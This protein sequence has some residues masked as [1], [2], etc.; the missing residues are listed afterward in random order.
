MAK[1]LQ[2]QT[3]FTSGELTPRLWAHVD[4]AKYKNGLKEAT[5]CVVL[6]H[7]PVSRRNGFK[8]INEVKDSSKNVRLLRFE[9][10][11]SDAYIL[12]MGDLYI[13]FY[14]NG[15]Q[16]QVSGVP[17]ELTTTYTQAEIF[18]ITYVQ[19]GRLLYIFHPNHPPA[20]L[21][22]TNS[23]SWVLSDIAFYPKP[24]SEEGWMPATTITPGATTGTGITFTA[25]TTSIFTAS[26]VGRQI[27]NLGGA[28]KASITAYTDTQHVVCTILENFPSTSSITSQNWKVD[29][30]PITSLTPSGSRIGAIV[31][32]TSVATVWEG[33]H[34]VSLPNYFLINNGVIKT[35][36]ITSTTVLVGEV[37][38][39]LDAVTASANWTA[40][41]PIWSSTFSYP[42]VCALHQQRLWAASTTHD[43]QRV[44][45]SESG[46]LT[47][48][49]AGSDDSDALDFNLSNREVSKVSWLGNIRGQLAI[50]TTSSEITIDSGTAAG[51]I[52]PTNLI[53]Q[54][55]GYNGSNLQ[56][57]V[58]LDDEILYIQRSGKKINAFS[59]NFQID[60]YVSTDLLFLAEHMPGD[61][62]VKELAY[63]HDPD[64]NIYA[65]LNDGDLLVCTY[66]K[67][68]DVTAWSRYSTQGNF[69]SINTI[70]TGINDEVWVVV[71]RTINGSTKRYIEKLDISTGEG[72]TDGFSDCYLTYSNPKTITAITNAN[73]GVVTSAAHGFNNGDFIKF[74]DIEGLSD[75]TGKTFIVGS[76]TT[77]TFNILDTSSQNFDTTLLGTF[78]SGVVHKLVTTISGLSYLEGQT[79]QVKADG[80]KH[81]D[82]VVSSG[83]IILDKPHY[84]VTVGLE[85]T[86][87]ITT[88]VKEYNQGE[89][90]M[91][92]QKVRWIR[93]V[94]RLYKSALPTINDQ[95]LPARAASDKMDNK[96]GL[97]TGDA[98]FGSLT[99]KDGFSSS[100]TISTSDPL[101]MT[102]LGIFGSMEGGSE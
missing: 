25:G 58:G 19:F 7:G 24:T 56:Q 15:G 75:I 14:T 34:E 17:Y 62:G 8:F 44:W 50:G 35:T 47:S 31:T 76:S 68:Q 64:R 39:S 86:T 79:V 77:N 16:V 99:W 54:V 101:P 42:A 95:F 20:Q 98:V 59:Y 60:N 84:E 10:D 30:S 21:T 52:T 38:K 87:T 36:S 55:R 3:N 29:L 88:L 45:A 11:Q 5:N 13:R 33:N 70:S 72:N 32:L 57:P 6:P 96:L 69:E 40:E 26:D 9:F 93:P 74:I 82:K 43:P 23:A 22:W 18:A 71:N 65:V 48:F 53:Q 27:H 90:S 102:L 1:T 63:A 41:V 80:A 61:L 92:G 28:G 73:P 49:G 81:I 4:V 89:G 67:E 51:P 12:E 2:I 37:Q 46:I 91:Q 83:S 94:I 85:Y 66:V 97:Y 78:T 100:L